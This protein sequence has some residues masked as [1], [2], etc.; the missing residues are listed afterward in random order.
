MT[1]RTQEKLIQLLTG[2]DLN[3]APDREPAPITWVKDPHHPTPPVGDEGAFTFGTGPTSSAQLLGAYGSDGD[4]LVLNGTLIVETCAYSVTPFIDITGPTYLS[5]ESDDDQAMILRDMLALQTTGELPALFTHPAVVLE[6]AGFAPDDVRVARHIIDDRGEQ[7]VIPDGVAA[8]AQQAP[9]LARYF[10][11]AVILAKKLSTLAQ[12]V[13][14]DLP[15]VLPAGGLSDLL[16][17]R[18]GETYR[19]MN[20]GTGKVYSLGRAMYHAAMTVVRPSH[21]LEREGTGL[22]DPTK[23]WALQILERTVNR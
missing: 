3:G 14:F 2:I 1:Q 7:Q 13:S 17:A 16:F 23:L 11:A 21:L 19:C 4:E 20:M 5:F 8:V 22:D 15:E 6:L 9:D 12:P 10:K 18:Q